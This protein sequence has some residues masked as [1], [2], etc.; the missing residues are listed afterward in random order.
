[1]YSPS[2]IRLRNSM[3]SAA[4]PALAMS[5][6]MA[7]RLRADLVSTISSRDCGTRSRIWPHRR[8]AAGVTL[9]AA[10]NEP[11]VT[12]PLRSIAW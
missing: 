8:Q 12:W 7:S 4:T 6:R 9:A 2:G 11:K 10:L 3:R 1:M 5:A